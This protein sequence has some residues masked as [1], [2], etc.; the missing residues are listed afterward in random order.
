MENVQVQ[1]NTV[2]YPDSN[3]KLSYS[4]NKCNTL[5]HMF[6]EFEK[7]YYSTK[8]NF[9]ILE[10]NDFTSKYPIIVIDTSRQCEVIKQSVIDIKIEFKWKD[11]FPANTIVHCLIISDDSYSLLK[12]IA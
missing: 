10:Y 12:I 6:T 2:K 5:Y 3:L 8:S 9:S 4:E 7:S 11:L 1:L